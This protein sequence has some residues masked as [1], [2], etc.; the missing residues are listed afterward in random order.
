MRPR[1]AI[2]VESY[3]SIDVT[4]S[5]IDAQGPGCLIQLEQIGAVARLS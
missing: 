4:E 1:T 5:G 3:L 2:E